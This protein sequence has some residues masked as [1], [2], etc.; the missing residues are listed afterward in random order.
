MKV[1]DYLKN[2]EWREVSFI[3]AKAVKDEATPYYHAEYKTSSLFHPFDK[4]YYDDYVILNDKAMPIDWLSGASWSNA[5]KGGWA[6]C[7]LIIRWEDLI[8]IY[9]EEQA[10]SMIEYIDKQIK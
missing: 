3:I 9:S 10:R 1:K 7:L 2:H 8:T 4:M 6:K 5:V